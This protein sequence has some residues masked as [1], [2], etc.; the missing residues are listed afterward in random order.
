MIRPLA[1]NHFNYMA[2]RKITFVIGNRA[3]YARVKPIVK[4]LP[5][6]TYRLVLFES[7]VLPEFGNVRDQI[8]RDIGTDNVAQMFTNISGGNLVS[9]TKSTGMAIVEFASEFSEHRPD[10]VV[11]IADRYEAL[12]AATAARY[13]NIPV[14]HVQG[15]ENS[16]SID[17][18]IRHAITK[19]ANIHLVTNGECAERIERMGEQKESVF[20]TGCPTIDVCTQL[21]DKDPGSIF[22]S[23]TGIHEPRFVL[24]DKYLIVAFHPVTTEYEENKKHFDALLSTVDSLNLQAIWLYPNIDAGNDLIRREIVKFKANDEKGHIHFF[25]HFAVEDYLLLLKNTTCI[26]GNSSVGIRESSFFGTPSVS[27]GTRQNMRM[28][29]ENVV[30][31]SMDELD[32]HAAAVTQIQRGPYVSSSLY[33]DGKAGERIASIL[34]TCSL[35]VDK[36]MSY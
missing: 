14:A 10:I 3:H 32:M 30:K 16:G 12:A 22:E 4:F 9:M 24:N 17:D 7:A 6:A 18:S 5:P 1:S 8:L 2:D 21:S 31:S 34:L 28:Q 36:H 27:V 13:M 15:G 23:H 11:V 19:L 20:I 29:A 25:K 35:S 33:G 26:I